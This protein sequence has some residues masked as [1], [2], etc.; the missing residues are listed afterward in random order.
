MTVK[1]F[2]TIL[3]ALVL[4]LSLASMG[5]GAH[6]QES[7][8][9]DFE[10]DIWPILEAKCVICHGPADAFNRL[11]LDSAEAILKGGKNG[12]V[13]MPGDLEASPMYVRTSLPAD[14]F[15]IMPAE[16]DPLTPEEV[17]VLGA[18]IEGGADFGGWE[19]LY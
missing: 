16:G 9:P 15:D 1:H 10:S 11:R 6:A 7:E 3:V 18:W 14:D 19:A 17:A 2:P 5:R 13:L 4:V 12:K 8:S